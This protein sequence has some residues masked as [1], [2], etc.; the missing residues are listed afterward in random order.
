M[1]NKELLNKLSREKLLEL[2]Q[3]YAKNWLAHDGSWFLAIEE[4]YGLE[5]A[6]EMDREAW[7]RFTVIEAQRL[8]EFLGLEQN[9]GLA[10]LKKALRYRLYSMLVEHEIEQQDENTL[11]YRIKDCKPQEARKRKGLAYFP[12]KSVGLVELSLFAKTIDPRFTT[13]A[14]SC[15][16]DITDADYSC[17]WK[18]TLQQQGGGK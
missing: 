16:P 12:C 10:G 11:L 2:C 6:V 7:R 9:S 5:M 14:I 4:H 8:I 3:I 13:E 17:I 1:Y 15:F 18:F